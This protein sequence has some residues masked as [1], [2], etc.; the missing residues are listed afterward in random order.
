MAHQ[1][2]SD[3]FFAVGEKA[4]HDVGKTLPAGT[5]LTC[6]QAH[7][8]TG[9]H[10]MLPLD[11]YAGIEGNYTQAE[12]FKCITR[13]DGKV[14]SVMTERFNIYQPVDFWGDFEP[15]VATGLAT[16]ETGGVL[17]EGKRQFGTLKI[18]DAVREVLKGDEI[19]AYL[20]GLTAF[21]GSSSSTW[22][23]CGTRPVCGNTLAMALNES[24]CN[25]HTVRHT[26]NMRQKIEDAKESILGVLSGLDKAVEA[27]RHLAATK[28]QRKE[29]VNYVCSVF[30]FNPEA[31]DNSTKA[32]N[33][34]QSVID[35]LEDQRGLE[36]V[37]A[38]RGTAWQAYNAVTDYLSHDYGHNPES[39]ISS[40][41]FGEAGNLNRKAL[42]LAMAVA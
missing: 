15:F 20:L 21:D 26:V 12:G 25:L 34:V 38:M 6:E 9:S 24:A 17:N 18:K 8:L 28:M 40:T 16:I 42:S 2:E 29:Q 27:Y 13:D 19:R 4:W 3:K 36:L 7:E 37:P 11:C 32:T 35:L 39:R 31:K 10:A 41:Y 30:D 23:F 14:L 22:R 5:E 33:K 1:I